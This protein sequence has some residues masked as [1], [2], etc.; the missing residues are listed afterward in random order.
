MI[1]DP[2]YNRRAMALELYNFSAST[3][4]QKVRLCLHEKGLDYTDRILL[5]SKGEHLSPEYLALNPGGVVPT[6]VHDGDAIVDSSVIL[7]YLDEVFPEISMM[8]AG[9]VAKARLRKWLRFSKRCRRPRSAI[10][11]ST[12]PW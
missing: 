11:R 2:W 1:S 7:E 9:A 5:S 4:S 10:R 8:P 12:W 3:C 6:L